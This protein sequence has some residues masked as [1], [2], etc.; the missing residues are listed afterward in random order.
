[1]AF[2]IMLSLEDKDAKSI[3]CP[4]KNLFHFAGGPLPET[5]FDVTIPLILLYNL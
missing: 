3:L 1:M 4:C 2:N 5:H